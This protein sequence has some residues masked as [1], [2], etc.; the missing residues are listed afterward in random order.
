MMADIIS[1]G[2]LE[3]FPNMV[4]ILSALTPWQ[5]LVLTAAILAAGVIGSGYIN[6]AFNKAAGTTDNKHGGKLDGIP[7]R[8]A[9]SHREMPAGM[10]EILRDEE[11]F[12][13]EWMDEEAWR[14]LRFEDKRDR[15]SR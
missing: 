11:E 7:I 3:H 4:R 10:R 15:W 12:D 13:A 1:N 14:K 2:L 5:V 6:G 8:K 9:R